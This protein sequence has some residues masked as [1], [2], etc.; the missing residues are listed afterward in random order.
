MQTAWHIPVLC[1][2]Q[3]STRRRDGHFFGMCLFLLS[4]DETQ[5]CVNNDS[6]GSSEALR[7]ETVYLHIDFADDRES[8][9]EKTD[10]NKKNCRS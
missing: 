5:S 3:R 10:E 1:M 9:M 4:D 2:L 7:A 8:N 6:I